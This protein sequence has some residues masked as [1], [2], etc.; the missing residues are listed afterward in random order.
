V[1][2]EQPTVP[3]ATIDQV[4][5]SVFMRRRRKD[6][7]ELYGDDITVA[8]RKVRFPEPKLDNLI[9]RLD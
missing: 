7:R 5:N 2:P 9:Y 1:P 3:Y 4:L 6:I 8:G